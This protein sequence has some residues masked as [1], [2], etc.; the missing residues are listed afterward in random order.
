MDSTLPEYELCPTCPACGSHTLVPAESYAGRKGDLFCAVCRWTVIGTP[1]QC[2]QAKRAEDAWN[3]RTDDR[4]G[5]WLR[6]LRARAKRNTDQLRLFDAE[7][8]RL[9][10]ASAK[11]RP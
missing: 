1:E 3:G 7:R 8:M 2:E 4:K 6:V 11:S 5:P 10:D 9:N